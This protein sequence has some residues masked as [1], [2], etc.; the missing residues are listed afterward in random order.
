MEIQFDF[1]LQTGCKGNVIASRFGSW[2]FANHGLAPMAPRCHCF[3]V[4]GRESIGSNRD[5]G[6]FIAARWA[7]GL[8]QPV[9]SKN[10]LWHNQS[11]TQS[12]RN[13][14]RPQHNQTAT[15]SESATQPDRNTTSP[16]HNQTA[17]RPVR[18]KTSPQHN[19]TA[20][21]P[22]RNTIRP[23]HNQSATQSDRNTTSP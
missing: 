14:T 1:N 2:C 3:A 13:T 11:A 12:V 17:T 9:R 15:Q 6:G 21:Q 7:R 10:R 5:L 23:Q 20:T 19:Q 8:T 4:N 16:Q 22:D 18:S